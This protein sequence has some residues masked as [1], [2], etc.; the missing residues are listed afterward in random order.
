MGKMARKIVKN[1][2]E[3]ITELNKALADEWLAYMQYT[4]ASKLVKSPPLIKLL[5]EVAKEELE[6]ANELTERI[7]QLE[8]T[9]I[10]D[11]KKFFEQSNCGYE[12]P[13]EDMKKVLKDSIKGEG[14]AINIYNKIAQ[15]SKETDPI[16]QQLVLHIM[17]EEEE[18]EQ[19]FQ[20][21]LEWLDEVS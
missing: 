12:V 19:K 3:I 20:D 4:F 1:A 16:T 9:P 2:D 6:H 11:P 15:M 13:T 18:H 7:I 5:N 17:V 10:V 8:G 14:C 21:I